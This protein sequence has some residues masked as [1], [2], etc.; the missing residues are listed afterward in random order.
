MLGYTIVASYIVFKIASSIYLSG[1]P[2]SIISLI[3]LIVSTLVAILTFNLF[4]A[5]LKLFIKNQDYYLSIEGT[6]LSA[7]SLA[8]QGE[9]VF[10]LSQLK[11][12][13]IKGGGKKLTLTLTHNW[14]KH[15]KVIVLL[16]KNDPRLELL[17][18]KLN[19]MIGRD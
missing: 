3:L 13:S 12:Y 15:D 16:A 4:F 11:S 9:Q 10:N 7:K 6:K 18:E 17:K 1:I 8:I 19:T 5:E 2:E 14:G